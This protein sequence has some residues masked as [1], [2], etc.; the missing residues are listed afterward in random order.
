MPLVGGT[1]LQAESEIASINMVYG[2]AAGGV[3]AMTASSSPGMSLKMEGIS[4][5]AGAELPIVVIDIMRGGPGLGNIAP[6]QSDYN[7]IVKGGGHGNYKVLALAP[8]SAQE[9]CDLTVLAFDLADKYRNPAV[10]MADGFIGQMMEP[11]DFPEP[12]TALNDKEWA[13]HAELK[14]QDRL[15]CSIDLEPEG[16]EKHNIFLQ[17]K[18]AQAEEGEVRYEEFLL[19]DADIVVIGYGVISRILQ[20]TVDLLR[21]QGLKVGMLRPITLWPFPKKRIVELAQ[22]AKSFVVVELSNGQMVDDVRLAVNGAKPIYFYGRMGGMIP[23]PIEVAEELK[24][25][26]KN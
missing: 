24:K 23:S 18:Y 20:S 15:I 4:Y 22:K 17:E 12:V 26:V 5:C 3:R 2:A 8:N 1:F 13:V 25:L 16:L 14:D 11:V 10:I 6:E 9:M 19:D 7:Q 21:K